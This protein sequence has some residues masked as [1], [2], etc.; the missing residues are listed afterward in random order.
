MCCHC[1]G[2]RTSDVLVHAVKTSSAVAQDSIKFRTTRSPEKD[3]KRMLRQNDIFTNNLM[4]N[5]KI[6]F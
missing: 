3:Q 2:V 5:A 4:G 1:A 6:Q